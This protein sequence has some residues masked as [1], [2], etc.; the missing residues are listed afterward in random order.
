M[1]YVHV[2]DIEQSLTLV[3]Q[4][5]VSLQ[6]TCV[7]VQLQWGQI[8]DLVVQHKHLVQHLAIATVTINNYTWDQRQRL[9]VGL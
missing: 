1:I 4:Q 3:G 7:W 2:E 8:L 9:Q 6:D 5:V